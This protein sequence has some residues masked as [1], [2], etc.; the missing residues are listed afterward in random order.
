MKKTSGDFYVWHCNWCDSTNQTVWT[1]MATEGL[2][3]GACHHN[4]GAVS[5]DYPV[6]MPAGISA[7]SGVYA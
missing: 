3:C 6:F 2:T 1:N 4:A 5:D 7:V